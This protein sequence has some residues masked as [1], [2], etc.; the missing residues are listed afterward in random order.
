[1][2]KRFL[3]ILGV[4]VVII[5][6]IIIVTGN[7]KDKSSSGS[8]SSGQPT[9]HV[10][11]NGQK[12]VTLQEYGDYQCPICGIYYSPLKQAQQQ[13]NNEIYFQFSNLPLVSIHPNA[14][15]AARAAEAAG[16]QNKYWEMHDMLYE[17]QSA[18]ESS[19]SPQS[20]FEG[21]AKQL[22]LDLTRFRQDYTSSKVNNSINA[23]LNAFNKTG[24]DMATPTI[25]INGK[26]I[27]NAQLSDP[28]TGQPSAEKIIAAVNA[29]I[30]AMSKT[31][32]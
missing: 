9:H 7:S 1:V 6:G 28:Q 8:G 21:Y 5:V 11:G 10:I 12:N 2:D 30:A 26:Y 16:L 18:W 32:Q 23:D 20:V 22:G 4:I 24:H 31:G 3:T 14:F 27:P 29:E 15:S 25:F 13:L 19:Q 17:N